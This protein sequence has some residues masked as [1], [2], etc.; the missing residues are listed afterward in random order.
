MTTRNWIELGV[1]AAV[2][3][4]GINV[5]FIIQKKSK[6]SNGFIGINNLGPGRGWRIYK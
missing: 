4:I 6:L 2:I 1:L 5:R 3:I